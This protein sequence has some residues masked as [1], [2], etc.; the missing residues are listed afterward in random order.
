ML[1][2]M[3][4]AASR[5]VLS[6]AYRD[7]GVREVAETV[8]YLRDLAYRCVAGETSDDA[9]AVT[10]AL[11]ADGLLVT[12]DH[13][14]PAAADVDQ[15]ETAVR[16]YVELLDGLAERSLGSRAEVSVRVAALGSGLDGGERLA[17]ELAHLVC[18][19]ARSAGT[20]V[21]LDPGHRARDA[22][23]VSRIVRELR[24]DHPDTGVVVRSALRS[25][26][27]RCAELAYAGSRVRL[28]KGDAA[29]PEPAS[30]HFTDG[31]DVDRSYV[32]CLTALMSGPGHPMLAT[33]D[34][35]LI[36]IAATLA[37]L[38]ERTPESFEYHLR[39]G[40]RPHEQRRLAGLGA[41]VRVHV[42]YGPE[43][44]PYMVDRL[45]DRPADLGF[46]V[47]APAGRK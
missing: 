31:H 43:W 18:A 19:V 29:P 34:P 38:H 17:T 44:Y 3:L 40:V 26:A 13:L 32:R 47:R 35:R 41:R 2:D 11:T 30:A 15:A 20:S 42:P 12:L 28:T 39:Y 21:T 10:D 7:G 8:P 36:D 23:A 1:G 37:V 14:C 24:T 33:H 4:A 27:G 46:L 9:L 45:A 5:G 16:D 6:A 22:E 25:A